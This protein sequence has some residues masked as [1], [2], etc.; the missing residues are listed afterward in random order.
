MWLCLRSPNNQGIERKILQDRLS[1]Y[2][3]TYSQLVYTYCH[4]Q[5]AGSELEGHNKTGHAITLSRYHRRGILIVRRHILCFCVKCVRSRKRFSESR[6]YFFQKDVY[7]SSVCWRVRRLVEAKV[8]SGSQARTRRRRGKEAQ[9]HFS[10]PLNCFSVCTYFHVWYWW[11]IS[12]S[13][14]F[15]DHVIRAN[16]ILLEGISFHDKPDL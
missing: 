8:W 12:G 7:E 10:P 13:S 1:V 3:Y 14:I 6:P 9:I 15:N 4:W 5:T 16:I 11:I 2:S